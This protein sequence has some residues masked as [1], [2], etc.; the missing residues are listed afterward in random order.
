MSST[1]LPVLFHSLP[2][3]FSHNQLLSFPESRKWLILFYSLERTWC[4]K[5]VFSTTWHIMECLF[6]KMFNASILSRVKAISLLK[7]TMPHGLALC[8]CLI[9]IGDV[10]EV[11]LLF[12]L[13]NFL[14]WCF[15][16]T[17]SKV[18][19]D[20]SR[21]H[22]HLDH[23]FKKSPW[24]FL[25]GIFD[26]LHLWLSNK[27]VCNWQEFFISTETLPI[28]IT[29]NHHFYLRGETFYLFS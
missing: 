8:F 24:T 3:S 7:H 27:M 4:I 6:S 28:L 11:L 20:T 1:F 17:L 25:F 10:P 5:G 9:F 14:N 19:K 15:W 12:R 26:S 2:T 18:F 21:K 13:V 23:D 16:T 22:K 29:V